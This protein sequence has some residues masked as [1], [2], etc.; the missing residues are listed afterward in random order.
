MKDTLAFVMAGG[1]GER[2]M[3]LTLERSKPAVP[4]GAIYRLIDFTLSNCVN[5]GIYRIIILPQYKSQSLFDHLEAGWHIFSQKIGHFLKIIPP[6]QRVGL[7]WY[8]GTA[9][10]IRQNL[11]LF[12]KH[13]PSHILILSGD[14]I[15]KMDYSLFIKYHQE[16]GADVTVSVLE[17]D[18]SLANQFGV[19]SVD[20]DFRIVAFQEKPKEQPP[21]IPGDP[22]HVLASMGV[23]VF[24]AEALIKIL[25][26]GDEL[27]FGKDIIPSL[28]P[29]HR[30]YA[31]PYRR[32]NAIKDYIYVTLESGERLMRM[33]PRTRDSA[34]W[35]DV[36][37]L[38]AYWNAN[39]DLTGVDPYFNLYGSQWPIHTYQLV[40][41][42][43]K[44]IFSNERTDGFRVGKA[45]D[46]LVAPGCIISGI[47][48]NSVLSYDVV[49]RSWSTVE[50]S[51]ILDRVVVGRHCTIRK[52]IIDKDN[53][54]PPG[55][56]IGCNPLKDREYF[57]VTQ[58]GIVVVPKGY[59]R[60]EKA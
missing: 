39:M 59:F 49:V 60:A 21:T 20:E 51:V 9:D 8:R 46:S 23:Y 25:R 53:V 36:G 58:R 40:A 1:R 13:K 19:A 14:H 6:Q 35:R 18:T 27:D 54:I 16:K 22:E 3:P 33:E 11:Y 42:P 32:Q 2:L 57:P 4:F 34:Y 30:V 44:F 24:E 47:V 52:A 31:Y 12:E 17:V 38:D 15:Y 7:D 29:S 41:P 37:N 43:A 56:E 50:E 45:L 5:S 26:S 48:R 28:L 55:T 10:S